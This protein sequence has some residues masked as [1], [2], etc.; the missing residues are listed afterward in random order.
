MKNIIIYTHLSHFL[1]NDGGTVVQYL[2]A[3]VLEEYGMNVRIYSNTGIK[4]QTLFL[5]IL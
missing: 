3:K 4:L 1:L 2:L 5:K